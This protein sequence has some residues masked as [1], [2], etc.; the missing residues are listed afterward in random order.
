MTDAFDPRRTV[1]EDVIENLP[2]PADQF[3]TRLADNLNGALFSDGT[4]I[5]DRLVFDGPVRVIHR[6]NAH[7]I[8]TEPGKASLTTVA[9]ESGKL[10]DVAVALGRSLGI[11]HES[12][13][14][15][16]KTP[17]NRDVKTER[18]DP[19]LD[20]GNLE[21]AVD[22]GYWLAI[23]TIMN[24]TLCLNFSDAFHSARDVAVVN[25]LNHGLSPTEKDLREIQDLIKGLLG[26]SS[27]PQ[28]VFQ[29]IPQPVS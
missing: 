16:G 27:Q 26:I 18:L 8:D 21:R 10:I 1:S 3:L 12:Y 6:H 11:R 13:L 29:P 25:K 28:P 22:G 7:T 9:D 2:V 24:H 4:N 20:R 15:I 19:E 14:A 23:H 17:V 5:L